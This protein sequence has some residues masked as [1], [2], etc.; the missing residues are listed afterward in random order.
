M[1]VHEVRIV[2]DELWQAAKDRQNELL[3]KYANTIKAA[4]PPRP[5]A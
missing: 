5:T 1:D 3:V 4:A 2:D